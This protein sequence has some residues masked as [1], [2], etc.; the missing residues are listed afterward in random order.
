MSVTDIAGG[1][2]YYSYIHTYM[3]CMKSLL[4][5]VIQSGTGDGPTIANLI[6]MCACGSHARQWG[7]G[8]LVGKSR[9]A[10]A[11]VPRG[12]VTE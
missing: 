3:N 12:R 4:A 5:L 2:H 9:G 10:A 6:H 7:A 11:G 1:A 8:G